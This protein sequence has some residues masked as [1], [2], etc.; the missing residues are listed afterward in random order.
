MID[1]VASRYLIDIHVVF[2]E[3][4]AGRG[5]AKCK[6]ARSISIL[7]ILSTVSV[8]VRAVF[9]VDIVLVLI[10]TRLIFFLFFREWSE[11]MVTPF[12]CGQITQRR[13]KLSFKQ[14]KS[15]LIFLLVPLIAFFTFIRTAFVVIRF[16]WE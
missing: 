14:F 7:V 1:F 11:V 15:I 9:I 4:S 3:W 6:C 12:F 13:L 2:E 8:T 10:L 5:V 16:T